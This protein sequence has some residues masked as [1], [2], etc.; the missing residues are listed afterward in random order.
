MCSRV[1]IRNV[2]N[3]SLSR[4]ALY[5]EKADGHEFR[6]HLRQYMLHLNF[7]SYPVYPDI[8]MRQAIKSDRSEYY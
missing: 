1:W 5:V 3:K 8:L 2:G 6:N 7:D 4:R